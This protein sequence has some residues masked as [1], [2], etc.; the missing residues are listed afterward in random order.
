MTPFFR[1]GFQV[2]SL[3]GL[4]WKRHGK[5]SKRISNRSVWKL[6]K[7]PEPEAKYAISP[8]IGSYFESWSGDWPLPD[9]SQMPSKSSLPQDCSFKSVHVRNGLQCVMHIAAPSNGIGPLLRITMCMSSCASFHNVHW[10]Y[11]VITHFQCLA[12]S[13]EKHN[14]NT[15][16]FCS[17]GFCV[18]VVVV[19]IVDGPHCNC[20]Y[21]FSEMCESRARCHIN[22]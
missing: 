21:V 1:L 13:L 10:T 22:N 5:C 11:I 7:S 12:F 9:E 14:F 3:V 17:V 15:T 16:V 19:V 4:G 2:S 8:T 18:Y 6:Q 20:Y